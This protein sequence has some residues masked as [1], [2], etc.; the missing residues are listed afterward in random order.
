MSWDRTNVLFLPSLWERAVMTGMTK[1]G[2]FLVENGKVVGPVKNLR[3]TQSIVEALQR[4]EGMTRERKAFG[5]WGVGGGTVV[6]TTLIK[7]WTFTG[8]A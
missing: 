4:I 2:T 3:F 5:S 1:D 8:K 7:D 6:P